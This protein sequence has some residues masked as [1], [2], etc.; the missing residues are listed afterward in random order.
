MVDSL[1]ELTELSCERGGGRQAAQH[2]DDIF[3]SHTAFWLTQLWLSPLTD[4]DWLNSGKIL[5]EL[6]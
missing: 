1:E 2:L 4:F 5:A 3:L 6:S